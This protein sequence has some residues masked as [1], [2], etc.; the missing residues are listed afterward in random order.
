[1]LRILFRQTLRSLGRDRF[2]SLVN[3]FGLGLGIACCLIGLLFV[4]S[5]L[6][7]DRQHQN[8][9]RIFHYGVE[10]TI[11]GVTSVQSSC[12]PGAGPLL[13]DFI[14][15]IES[16]V[17]IGYLGEIMVRQKDRAFS[18]EDFLWADP[19]IFTVFTHG[20]VYGDLRKALSRDNAIVLTRSFAGKIFGDRNPLG[21]VLEVENQGP[22]EVTGVV[23]DPPANN[24]LQFSAL[25]SYSTQ[26]KGMNQAELFQ[27]SKLSGGM[28]DELYFLFT[29]GF[30][31]A[32]FAARARKFYEK[33][34]AATDRIHYRH[35]AEPLTG[36]HL[37]SIINIDQAA[38][39]SRFLFWF[40]GIV[41]LILFLA[42][43]N[44]VNLATSRAGKRAKEIGVKK[45]S[46]SSQGQLVVHL[47]AESFFFVFLAMLAGIVLAAGILALSPLN[48][49]IGKNLQVNLFGNPQLL[50]GLSAIWITV[51][52]LAGFYPAFY[53]SR[54]SPVRSIK[55]G[56]AGQAAGR[57]V[58]QGLVMAQFVI[59]IG[60]LSLTFLMNRQLDFV[61]SRDLGFT[62]DAV[63]LIQAAD[64]GLRQ[65]LG[66]F[67]NEVLRL[68]GVAAA[69][70]SDS[71]PGT[72]YTGYAFPWESE[73]GG[74]QLH[75]FASLEA[76]QDYF[77]TL[78]IQ[79]VAGRNFSRPGSRQDL[80]RKT[81]EFIVTENLVKALNW[82]EAV[83]KRCELGT[84]I[85][86]ARNFHYQ[87]LHR[88]VRGTF[89]VQP[90]EPPS[91]LNVRLRGGRIGETLEALRSRWTAFAPG[92]PFT[93][94]F[95]DQRLARFYEQD[96]RQ[97][98]LAIIFSSLCLLIS[99]L[100]L[101]ALASF[102]IEQRTK[103]I[104]I[105][106]AIGAS[107]GGVVLLL[108]RR[109][110]FWVALANVF[111][112]PLAFLA[113]RKWLDNFAFRTAIV[114][115]V[116]IFPALLVLAI[117]L[118]T[119][120]FQALRAARANPVDSLRYE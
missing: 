90:L 4:Q 96:Q 13:K 73:Q 24:Q 63:V 42:G 3:I 64:S 111:A 84:V 27:P 45:V 101:F 59:A 87:S 118:A 35:L 88:D 61:R 53:L 98:K 99:C 105:R 1:M 106:K 58:R 34:Q 21:E 47:L 97:Q 80:E 95:M 32:D 110:L 8:H 89:I 65:R 44:Y 56:I 18:E 51:S 30:T 114:P 39:N 93:Y 109:F 29:P 5:E 82:K 86:V 19:S 10:M 20:A 31:A 33:Y 49:V 112:W 107:S 100:G 69:S 15:E 37:R 36:I 25:L 17:R 74:I 115:A 7:Y 79:L 81:M 83:G 75:A 94:S 41:L 76:D 43:V 91:Y 85:G 108:T 9:A 70:L 12:N 66:A 40:C 102:H 55:A 77:E 54:I 68:P 103:E 72:G 117:A 11:G 38:A 16:F 60:G 119:V 71:V 2:H 104:G 28:G 14:P 6:S 23:A 67:K 50:L 92:H 57:F 48:Q 62:R 46:G 120:I 78:G 52:L 116:F 26:F 113:T 22:F